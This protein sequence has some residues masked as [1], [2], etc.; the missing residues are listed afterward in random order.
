MPVSVG[1]LWVGLMLLSLPVP[2]SLSCIAGKADVC[3]NLEF[4]PGSNLAGEGFDITK[5]QRKGAYVID[6]SLWMLQDK[7]C[8][9]CNNPYLGRKEKLPVSIVD[10][11][12]NHQ[13]NMK[14]SSSIH[15]SSE[16]LV[17]SS[18][19]NVENSW[20]VNLEV[21]D[22]RGEGKLMLAGTQSKLAQYSMEKTKKDR[23]S[24][25]SHQVSCS[26]YR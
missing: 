9:I 12:P 2:I 8:T 25:T 13:C 1:A 14:V 17:T 18:S 16:S 10:W 4:A 3:K 19:N 11:R 21:Q 22:K 6:V 24:F 15:E 26:Y 23:F 20:Q 5:M 7:T